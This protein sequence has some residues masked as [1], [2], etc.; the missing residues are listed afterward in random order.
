MEGG[1]TSWKP[2][3]LPLPPPLPRDSEPEAA[4]RPWESC[5]EE[6]YAEEQGW[7][8]LPHPPRSAVCPLRTAHATLP[9]AGGTVASLTA[10]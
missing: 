8:D 6:G 4:A 5:R 10:G 2:L 7:R 1:C 3:D 9:P